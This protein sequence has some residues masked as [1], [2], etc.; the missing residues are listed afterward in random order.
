ML[1]H[2]QDG[3][4]NFDARYFEVLFGELGEDLHL[5]SVHHRDRVI[6]RAVF[7]RSGEYLDYFLCGAEADAFALY[8]NHFLLWQ[9]ILRAKGQGLRVLHLG[10]GRDSLY[11]FKRGFSGQTVPFYLGAKV[12][13]PDVYADLAARRAAAL[14]VLKEVNRGFFPAHRAGYE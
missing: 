14:P 9:M 1:R 7:L 8:P 5:V 4:L 12:H 11:F 13:L 10:G 6:A 3:Y 2:Q